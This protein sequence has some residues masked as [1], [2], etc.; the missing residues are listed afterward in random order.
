MSYKINPTTGK[1]DYYEPAGEA[2]NGLPSG[3]TA[4][5]LLS[6]IDG[7]DYNA[8]WIDQSAST[9]NIDG[10]EPDTNYGGILAIDG[11]GV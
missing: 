8:E 6:K 7:T 10:G 9:F 3:G 1:L 4:G 11:G 5:Q 2:S